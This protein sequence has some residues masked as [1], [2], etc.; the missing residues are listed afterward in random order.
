MWSQPLQ[1]RN[2]PNAQ[3][4]SGRQISYQKLL[5]K[6]QRKTNSTS[7]RRNLSRMQ[8]SDYLSQEGDSIYKNGSEGTF[9]HNML[10]QNQIVKVQGQIIQ[11]LSSETQFSLVCTKTNP[12]QPIQKSCTIHI[13]KTNLISEVLNVS[14][15]QV[16]LKAAVPAQARSLC[17]HH[18]LV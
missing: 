17:T 11:I 16:S 2:H 5:E 18:V 15:D 10:F 8:R 12:P 4:L 7:V 9:V 14:T 1:K 13:V 3:P 6:S